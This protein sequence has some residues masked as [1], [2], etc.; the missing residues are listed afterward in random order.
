MATEPTQ[1]TAPPSRCFLSPLQEHYHLLIDLNA[2]VVFQPTH[3]NAPSQ[4]QLQRLLASR[5][6]GVEASWALRG[7]SNAFL[8]RVPHWLGREEFDLDEEFWALY[9]Y[10]I[11]PWQTLDG[12]STTSAYRRLVI[13]IHDFP[14]DFIHPHYLRQATGVMGILVG[15]ARA[16]HE[17]G[18]LSKIRLLI[19]TIDACFVPP[20]VHVFHGGRFTVCP[21]SIENPILGQDDPNLPPGTPQENLQPVEIDNHQLPASNPPYIPPYR[22]R[23]MRLPTHVPDPERRAAPAA[24]LASQNLA[25]CTDKCHTPVPGDTAI[26][27]GNLALF[28]TGQESDFLRRMPNTGQT[29]QSPTTQSQYMPYGSQ[30]PSNGYPTVAPHQV[31]KKNPG[32]RIAREW[33]QEIIL[34]PSWIPEMSKNHCRDCTNCSVWK[35]H[36]PSPVKSNHHILPFLPDPIYLR[37]VSTQKKSR[38]SS[39]LGPK[40]K[41]HPINKSSIIYLHQNKLT[42]PQ[43]LPSSMDTFTA[44]EELLIQKFIGLQTEESQSPLIQ[45]PVQAAATTNWACSFLARVFTDSQVID[46]PFTK[47][48]RG[49][50]NAD[51]AT[52]F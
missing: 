5:Y 6:G 27:N 13:A 23:V 10:S 35:P 19:E 51:P 20:C 11:L 41:T 1:Y 26:K 7:V 22:Q 33:K 48:M 32:H 29:T 31:P 2:S 12:S 52:T 47:T 39:I 16:S 38:H 34:S 24:E 37:H 15:Y 42:N 30:I 40:P 17:D 46:A 3:P 43:T 36:A 8:V 28:T 50:W 25:W 49:A 44:E 14:I 45:L 9:H 4:V 18:N 21:V